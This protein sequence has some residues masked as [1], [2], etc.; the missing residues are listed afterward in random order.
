MVNRFIMIFKFPYLLSVIGVLLLGVGCKGSDASVQNSSEIDSSRICSVKFNADSA[1]SFVKAQCDFGARTPNSEAIE[2]CGDYI[3]R[4]FRGYGLDVTEQRTV[5]K[6]WDGKDLRC[7]NI[8]AAYKPE[9][10]DRIIIAGH[11][12]ARPWA[13]HDPDSTL[14]RTPVMAAN[15]GASGIAVIME[16][17]RQIDRLNLAVGIDFI[18]FD[19]EDYGAPYWAPQEAQDNADNWCL[20]SQYWSRNPHRPN[21]T[22]RYGVLLDM[23]GGRGSKF[24]YEGFSLQFAQDVVVRA[25]EAARYAEAADFFPQENGGYVT[26][27]HVPMN[28]IALIPTINIIP[29]NKGANFTSHWHTT[30]DT[31]ENIDPATLRAVGQTVLQLLSEEKSN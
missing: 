26:D 19:A 24:H 9:L 25:W 31:P 5:V 1:F 4:K 11:Y 22:A 7:R 20:G 12:D 15:D 17:A 2:R 27:D 10:A 30:H 14:H 23:V 21:Y 3:V 18:C 28:T 29:Y 8:I 6:G 16:I 13:D